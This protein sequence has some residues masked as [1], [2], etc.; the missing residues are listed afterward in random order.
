MK[1]NSMTKFEFM[2]YLDGA[3]RLE[4][5]I[6]DG[7]IS[8]REEKAA[9][10]EA[11]V[12]DFRKRFSVIPD[13][14]RLPA[15]HVEKVTDFFRTEAADCSV[16]EFNWRLSG[17]FARL[18]GW[19]EEN[20]KRIPAGRKTTKKERR[21]QLICGGFAL[22][23]FLILIACVVLR[24]LATD[25]PAWVLHTINI[26]LAL[27]G[28]EGFVALIPVALI[29]FRAKKGCPVAEEEETAKAAPS[30]HGKLKRALGAVA[31]VTVFAL[32]G[33]GVYIADS[34]GLLY[35]T[36]AIHFDAE[37]QTYT[38]DV[39]HFN[40]HVTL[41]LPAKAGYDIV[42]VE[43]KLTGERLFDSEG[44]SIGKVTKR[45]L[46]DYEGYKLEVVYRPHT[47]AASLCSAA[48]V[49]AKTF[50][51][52]VE[53]EPDDV[54]GEP[55][56]LDGYSFDGWYTDPSFR[57]PFSGNFEDYLEEALVLYPHYSLENWAIEWDLQGGWMVD[58]VLDRYNV[59]ADVPLPKGDVVLRRG[60]DLVGWAYNGRIIEYFP[61]TTRQDIT[62]VAVWT[63]HPYTLTYDFGY[64][65]TETAT[66]DIETEM[67]LEEPIRT[68][69][70]F[71]G[72]YTAK[73]RQTKI[74]R[75]ALGT[76][77][78]LTVY[79]SWTPIEYTV[80]YDLAGGENSPLNPSTYTVEHDVKLFAPKWTGHPFLGWFAPA[81]SEYRTELEALRDGNIRLIAEWGVQEH[82]ITV[83]PDN[84][85]RSFV[86][87]VNYGDLYSITLPAYRG[88]EFGGLTLGGEPF[89]EV[90]IYNYDA[91]LCL[92]AH[93]EAKKYSISYLDGGS[94]VFTQE[95]TFGQPYTLLFPEARQDYEFLGWFDAETEGTLATD[96]VFN[97]AENI[98]LY[99]SWRKIMQIDLESG[100]E[101]TVDSS[102]ER[103]Y[104]TGSYTGGE[105]EVLTD[106][107]IVISNRDDDLTLCLQNAGFRGKNDR[108]AIDCQNSSYILTVLLTGENYVEGGAGSRGADGVGGGSMTE[109]NRNGKRGQDGATAL[110]AGIV[111]FKAAENNCSLT[112]RSGH[113]GDGGNGGISKDRSR[114]WLNYLPDGGNG[115]DSGYA[116]SCL[117]YSEDGVKV[118][119]E[120][121]EAGKGG[122]RGSRGDWWKAACYGSNGKDGK[123][124]DAI[125]Y[126]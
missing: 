49:V 80:E 115:G 20:F 43:D 121:N 36:G 24:E 67:M 62:L 119:F 52:T 47:Y 73:N 63:P 82:T 51:F 83:C 44:V 3:K 48:G 37:G 21:K 42:G 118:S 81:A 101:Y 71:A 105:D 76:A 41:K 12:S 4:R 89:A 90:G 46:S 38:Q 85:E 61:A 77:E 23:G 88:Y 15:E 16:Q 74:E 124:N 117:K 120:Q 102:V 45:D 32:V 19:A 65:E 114:A 6:L 125:N 35:G 86:Q 31:V 104:V 66:F 122:T 103:V 54:I 34:T 72:W 58:G 126:K 39:V 113:G 87:K 53:D 28:L 123:Q 69:Y 99:A 50:T 91:D 8:E 106:I 10:C 57:H 100:K 7:P 29:F 112:L 2:S 22:L 111:R 26:V 78:D 1:N 96:G 60:Y 70:N 56:H 9:I 98:T 13:D 75:V 79:A 84:G 27:S 17:H 64:G 107:C 11:L 95:V 93:Y 109:S 40:D 68:G 92:V 108:N 25:V 116:I 18:E 14:T 110:E 94:T 30:K 55:Q 59:L 5:T 33:I 97:A